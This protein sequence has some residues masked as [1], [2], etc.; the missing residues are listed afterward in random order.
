MQNIRK[1]THPIIYLK[2]IWKSQS[3]RGE[4]P[5]AVAV[6]PDKKHAL[7]GYENGAVR[8]HAAR[9]A[10]LCACYHRT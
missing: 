8:L 7:V 2:E 4:S 5:T 9:D 3:P 6:A 1:G 10:R